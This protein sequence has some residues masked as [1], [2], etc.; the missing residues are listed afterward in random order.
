M[1]TATRLLE[2]FPTLLSFNSYTPS[3]FTM[4]NLFYTNT[5]LLN[6]LSQLIFVV[7]S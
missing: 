4:L 7:W 1:L 3:I 5:V 6:Y 2:T